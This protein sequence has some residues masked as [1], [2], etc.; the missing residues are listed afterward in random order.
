[1]ERNRYA[2][3]EQYRPISPWAYIGYTLLFSLPI[4]GFI[5]LIVFSF[6]DNN[7][8]RRNYARSYFCWL[9]LIVIIF[10]TI[11]GFLLLTGTAINLS[12][13]RSSCSW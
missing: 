8:N 5:L 3:P 9:L 10:V 2:I 7:Y 6:N 12:S 4:A 1:M 11:I 13:G